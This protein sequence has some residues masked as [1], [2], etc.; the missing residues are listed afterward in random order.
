VKPVGRLVA[1]PLVGAESM[2]SDGSVTRLIVMLKEGNRAASQQLW[3]GYFAR[4][5]RLARAR[6][7]NIPSRVADEED[8]A[9]SAFD[10]FYR[11]AEKGQ[12]PRLEDREDLWQLLFVLTVRKAINLVNYQGRKSRGGGRVQSLTDLDLVGAEA[13]FG[14]EPSPDLAAQLTEECQRLLARL[15][16]ESLRT[17]ALWK[18]EG[19]TNAEIGERLGCVP[20]TVE[21]KLRAIRKVWS[22]E[23]PT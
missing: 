18:M 22:D 3:E 15:P 17:V 6:L 12:F 10:S 8:V 16:D 5:V 14:T 7:R 9:L 19:Y 4:L 23:A 21:R 2:P 11:R 1:S 20:Q 13:I